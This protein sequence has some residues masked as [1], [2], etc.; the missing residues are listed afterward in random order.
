M[1][2]ITVFNEVFGFHLNPHAH[3]ERKS[4]KDMIDLAHLRGRKDIAAALQGY[5]E[6]EP[7]ELAQ[8]N[9]VSEL[10][11]AIEEIFLRSVGPA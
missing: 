3:Y 9:T 4:A 5:F 10:W 8:E 11:R 7:H 1:H 6:F 2:P